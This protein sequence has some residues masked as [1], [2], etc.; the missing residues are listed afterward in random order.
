MT[1]DQLSNSDLY[2]N[3]NP[4]FQKAFEFLKVHLKK[5][6]AEGTYELNGKKLYAMVSQYNTIAYDNAVW[7]KHNRYMDIHFIRSGKESIGW[8]RFKEAKS[9][10]V[11]DDKD[12][13]SFY[14]EISGIMIPI[15]AGDF[16]ILYPDDVHKPKCILENISRVEKVVIKVKLGSGLPANRLA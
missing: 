14:R 16:M 4:Y 9:N 7:E 8:A 11:Y 6:Y 12:D 3:A 13:V 2:V 5:P 1:V 15:S 10:S